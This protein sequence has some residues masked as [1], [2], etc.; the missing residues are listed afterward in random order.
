MFYCWVHPY[1]GSEFKSGYCAAS[2]LINLGPAKCELF[3]SGTGCIVV[4]ANDYIYLIP[5]GRL[6]KSGLRNSYKNWERI[7]KSAL[8][9]YADY[10]IEF[11]EVCGV[12]VY[13]VDRLYS[14]SVPLPYE[15]LYHLNKDFSQCPMPNGEESLDSPFDF[16]HSAVEKIKKY[17]DLDFSFAIN[18]DFVALINAT[19]CAMHGDLTP[20]NVMLDECGDL[21]IIDLDRFV[22]NGVSSLDFL[23]YLVEE[24]ASF[25]KKPW[26]ELLLIIFKNGSLSSSGL[27]DNPGLEL[28]VVYYLYRVDQEIRELQYPYTSYIKKIS[29]LGEKLL[30]EIAR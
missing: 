14:S 19:P 25:E 26:T 16:V 5:G 17:C 4:I 8:K 20:S 1:T 18:K 15:K 3:V 6:S 24:R 10:N 12:H 13:K 22:F 30:A 21:K 9:K 29:V 11:L 28:V 23:H 2:Y 7:R 27:V